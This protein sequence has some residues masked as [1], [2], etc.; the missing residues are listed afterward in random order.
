MTLLP[1]VICLGEA[2][3]DRLAPL[4]IDPTF[5]SVDACVDRLGGAPANVACALAR[6]GIPTAFVGRLGSD[7]HGDS[8]QSLM[9][10]RG[11]SL[12]GLQRDPYRPTRIVFVR[13]TLDGDRVFHG[14]VGDRGDGFSDD[15]LD[16]SLLKAVWPSLVPEAQWLFVGTNS[17]SAS[18]SSD[19]LLWALSESQAAGLK[20]ALDINWRPTLRSKNNQPDTPP[21]SNVLALIQSITSVA[22][23]IKLSKEEA[24]W[25]FGSVD[26]MAISARLR[27]SPDVIIT[28]GRHPIHWLMSG[29]SG[30]FV[31][32]SLSHVSD[33]TGAGDA[34]SA[35]LLSQLLSNPSSLVQPE[36]MI[37]FAAACG[38]LVCRDVG[39]IDPQPDLAMVEEYLEL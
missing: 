24:L 35:A 23:L 27:Q 7:S 34:F 32:F 16:L 18:I 11:V 5:S 36:H 3:V 28:D 9:A 39:A 14:F 31:P 22:S 38:A 19:A 25:F 17:L 12:V 29:Q 4:G 20:I 6:L 30:I 13:R 8:F 10:D 26:P 15:A 1:R 21:D 2:L 37:R 33:T